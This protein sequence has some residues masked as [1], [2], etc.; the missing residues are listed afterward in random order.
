MVEQVTIVT[1]PIYIGDFAHDPVA[2]HPCATIASILYKLYNLYR[3]RLHNP[4]NLR[5]LHTFREMR[6]E[7]ERQGTRGQY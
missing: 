1:V 4:H 2:N 5:N 3:F 7:G 6:R